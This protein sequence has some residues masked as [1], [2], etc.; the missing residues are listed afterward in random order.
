MSGTED[1]DDAVSIVITPMHRTEEG[2]WESGPREGANFFLVEAVR[3]EGEDAEVVVEC[4]DERSA[5]LAARVATATL[6][7]LGLA[8]PADSEAA[9]FDDDTA[10]ILAA[11][12]TP[13]I[14]APAG[15]WQRLAGDDD[16]EDEP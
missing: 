5:A 4:R 6:A 14:E 2:I 15:E 9:A 13:E 12:P 3:G 10:A 11:H 8:E 1:S 7:A 16:D